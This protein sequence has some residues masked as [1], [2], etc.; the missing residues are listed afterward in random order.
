MIYKKNNTFAF[1]KKKKLS[2][3]GGFTASSEKKCDNKFV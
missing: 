3:R 1:G 2:G